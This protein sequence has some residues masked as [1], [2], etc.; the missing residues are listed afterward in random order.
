[1]EKKVTKKAPTKKATTS[2]VEKPVG[3]VSKS[4]FVE[5]VVTAKRFGSYVEGDV[6]KMHRTTA[7]G[8]IKNKAVKEK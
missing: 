3:L 8:C 2:K 1:M 6:I 4:Q 7:L 5:V